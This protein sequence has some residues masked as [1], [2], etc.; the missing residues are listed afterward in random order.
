[1]GL[2]KKMISINTDAKFSCKWFVVCNIQLN[3][4]CTLK[5]ILAIY[6]CQSIKNTKLSA[7]KTQHW[8][9][10]WRIQCQM[11]KIWDK[12]LNRRRKP[13]KCMNSWWVIKTSQPHS[14]V[15]T[16][17][18]S[19]IPCIH[20]LNIIIVLIEEFDLMMHFTSKFW[21]NLNW[22]CEKSRIWLLRDS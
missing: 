5:I 6:A 18:Q 13:F 1:M 3:I 2:L 22:L 14:H 12:R 21:I 15:C 9:K 11:F 16:V 19:L 4:L 10:N 17:P 8:S 20:F 7:R